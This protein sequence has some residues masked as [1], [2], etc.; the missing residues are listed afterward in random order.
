MEVRTEDVENYIMIY[1]GKGFL[2][3]APP[4]YP[5]QYQSDGILEAYCASV[6]KGE[7]MQEDADD[8]LL[9]GKGGFASGLYDH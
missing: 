4:L 9:K 5:H 2:T 8:N 1:G 6:L 7:W 3:F